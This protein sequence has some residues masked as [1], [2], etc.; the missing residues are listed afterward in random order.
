MMK[1]M[2]TPLLFALYSSKE[3]QINYLTLFHLLFSNIAKP[4]EE[5]EVAALF[6]LKHRE[7]K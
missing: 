4:T 7:A 6:T 5:V 3:F 2:I 1:M